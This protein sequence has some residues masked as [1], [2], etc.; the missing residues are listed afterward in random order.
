MR[1]PVWAVRTAALALVLGGL[2]LAIGSSGAT[3]PGTATPVVEAAAVEI[4]VAT[5]Y[6]ADNEGS[7]TACGQIYKTAEYTTASNTLPCGSVVTVTNLDTG[8]A[9]TV[10]VTDRG[11]FTYP[12]VVD[13]SV[14]AFSTIGDLDDGV[15]RVAVSS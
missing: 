13:L 1:F 5:W 2:V 11:A 6:G 14:A 9:V 3:V 12:I 4:G 7:T 15:V 8:A 10:T